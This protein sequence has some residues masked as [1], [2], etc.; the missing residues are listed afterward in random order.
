MLTVCFTGTVIT[1]LV[2]LHHYPSPFTPDTVVT[3]NGAT[4]TP[5]NAST[6]LPHASS[7]SRLATLTDVKT[8]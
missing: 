4:N 5:T 6:L 7:T 3:T 8:L 2:Y 1:L